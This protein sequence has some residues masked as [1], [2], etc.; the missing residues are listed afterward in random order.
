MKASTLRRGEKLHLYE[1]VLDCVGL[2]ECIGLPSDELLFY[3]FI[4]EERIMNNYVRCSSFREER[5][6]ETDRGALNLP[7]K[8]AQQCIPD[9]WIL[10]LNKF[11][12][13]TDLW[14]LEFSKES[15]N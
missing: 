2:H 6:R 11:L 13:T 10:Y 1:G 4:K 7:V 14:I 3:F 12:R 8:S 5:E 9:I 15:P